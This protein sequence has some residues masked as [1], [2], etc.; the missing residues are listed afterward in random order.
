MPSKDH[1]NYWAL[2]PILAVFDSLGWVKISFHRKM[3]EV[4]VFVT[5][6]QTK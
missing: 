4:N 2:A 3:S 5:S 1:H 6:I